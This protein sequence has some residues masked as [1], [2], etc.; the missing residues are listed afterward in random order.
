VNEKTKSFFPCWKRKVASKFWCFF[1]N[2]FWL[3]YLFTLACLN[4]FWKF[5]FL[6]SL[7]RVDRNFLSSVY[8]N[9]SFLPAVN[10]PSM[11]KTFLLSMTILCL[12][13]Y[14]L[15][16]FWSNT[17]THWVSKKTSFIQHNKGCWLKFALPLTWITIL[18]ELN[19]VK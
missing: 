17:Y 6:Y 18:G 19:S 12:P 9:F 11:K 16:N 4:R 15:F 8:W 5:S 3:Y 1:D 2:F 13:T 7:K 10:Y 14:T